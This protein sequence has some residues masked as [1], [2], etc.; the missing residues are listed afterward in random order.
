VV[1]QVRLRNLDGTFELSHMDEVV[2]KMLHSDLL[3]DIALPRIPHRCH[4]HSN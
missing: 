4:W 3:F 1:L 2:D